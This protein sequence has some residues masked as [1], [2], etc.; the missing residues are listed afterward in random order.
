VKI[1]S[2]LP[3]VFCLACLVAPPAEGQNWP[4]IP[5]QPPPEVPTIPLPDLEPQPKAVDQNSS[6]GAQSK[7]TDSEDADSTTESML[8][9]CKAAYDKLQTDNASLG[10]EN[11]RLKSKAYA[12]KESYVEYFYGDYARKRSEIQLST[13]AWQ[14][15]A[16]K[17]LAWL[18]VAV[19][20]AGI[21]F[22]GVQLWRATAPR[23]VGD[24]SNQPSVA[25]P[26]GTNIEL[27]WQNVRVTSSVIGL[28][29]LVISVV[30]LYLFLKEVYEVKVITGLDAPSSAATPDQSHQQ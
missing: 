10:A 17:V 16:S 23:P 24:P 1:T 13:F 18:V 12:A 14:V 30:Y 6:E 26:L 20:T 19:C 29:V 27:S 25:D 9:T 7:K 4:D 2:L 3:L 8:A 15:W 5:E 28:V 11:D 22:S 21:A